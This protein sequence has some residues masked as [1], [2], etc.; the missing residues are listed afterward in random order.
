M[1]VVIDITIH[2]NGREVDEGYFQRNRSC[3]HG[4]CTISNENVRG[5]EAGNHKGCPYNG[6]V[7]AYFQG[8][9]RL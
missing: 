3:R 7:R 1:S 8:N 4:A 9:D 5:A 2:E 6:S